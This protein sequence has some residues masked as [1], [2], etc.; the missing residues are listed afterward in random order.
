MALKAVLHSLDDL[1]ERLKK[2]Y[3]KEGG[4]YLLKVDDAEALVDVAGLKSALE[5][6]RQARREAESQAR[7]APEADRNEL[8]RLRERLQELRQ[9]KARREGRW[10]KFKSVLEEKHAK[11]IADLKAELAEARR[12]SFALAAEAGLTEALT[13]VGVRPEL[14]PFVKSH[15]LPRVEMIDDHG[16][17][18]AVIDGA[19]L[20]D[21]AAAW[22]QT[23]EGRAVIAAPDNQG[24]GGGAPAGGPAPEHDLMSRL[25]Q[26]KQNRDAEAVMRLETRI[27]NQRRNLGQI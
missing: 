19:S 24:A 22:A 4:K 9:D 27:F 8:R 11:T 10:D 18:R 5:K 7:R 20:D 17:V 3:R 14:L 23:P 12:A 2:L 13:A 16:S 6:E 25:R 26:A 15:L 1:D 21:F